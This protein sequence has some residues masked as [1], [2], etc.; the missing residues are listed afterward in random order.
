MLVQIT[1]GYSTSRT[2][3]T[4]VIVRPSKIIYTTDAMKNRAADSM[5][6]SAALFMTRRPSLDRGLLQLTMKMRPPIRRA[7]NVVVAMFS[8]RDVAF[9]A[10]ANVSEKACAE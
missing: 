5:T 6:I 2:A 7:V 8:P 3:E 4:F 1:S 10:S 9:I